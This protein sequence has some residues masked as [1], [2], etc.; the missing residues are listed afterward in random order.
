MDGVEYVPGDADAR[1]VTGVYNWVTS[2]SVRITMSL[3]RDR[4]FTQELREFAEAEAH[5]TRDESD[6]PVGGFN[7]A[8]SFSDE[9]T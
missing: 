4:P 2:R 6:E 7:F 3:P 8:V 1:G 5:R 9:A